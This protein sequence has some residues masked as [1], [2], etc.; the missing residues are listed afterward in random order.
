MHVAAPATDGKA[1]A[2]S[3]DVTICAG[4]PPSTLERRPQAGARLA[5]GRNPASIAAGEPRFRLNV[6]QPL[7]GDLQTGGARCSLHRAA[8]SRSRSGPIRA[9]AEA[10][11]RLASVRELAPGC[12]PTRSRDDAGEAGQKVFFRARYAGFE[13]KTAARACGELK[14]LKIECL[15]MK[16][17]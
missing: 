10:D 16:A 5:G 17:E 9:Q 8:P 1:A 13:A 7:G 3:T 4:A 6:R 14:K 2:L 15:V 11:E 12:W